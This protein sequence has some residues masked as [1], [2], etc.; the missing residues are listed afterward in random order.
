MKFTKDG[1]KLITGIRNVTIWIERSGCFGFHLI[2]KTH[3]ELG[4]MTIDNPGCI[5]LGSITYDY[6]DSLNH[7]I[8]IFAAYHTAEKRYEVKL[9]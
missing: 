6:L 2:I 4:N 9:E 8:D 7:P 1:D 5:A 3:C